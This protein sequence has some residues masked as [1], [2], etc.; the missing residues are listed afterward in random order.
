MDLVRRFAREVIVLSSG[1]VIFRGTPEQLGS[2]PR[3]RSAYLGED[4]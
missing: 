2:D 1:A 3:V 4:A